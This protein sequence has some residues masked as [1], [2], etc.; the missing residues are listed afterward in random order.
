MGTGNAGLISAVRF[1]SSSN[2]KCWSAILP[3]G[4]VISFVIDTKVYPNMVMFYQK[5]KKF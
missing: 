3:A 1:R 4:K 2:K 5:F